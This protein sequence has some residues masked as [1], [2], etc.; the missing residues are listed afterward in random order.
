MQHKWEIKNQTNTVYFK[1]W[2]EPKKW[3]FVQIYKRRFQWKLKLIPPPHICI[4]QENNEIMKQS[5]VNNEI[6]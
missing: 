1:K 3:Y 2:T 6:K 5:N 4:K